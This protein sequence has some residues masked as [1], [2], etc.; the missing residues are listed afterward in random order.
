MPKIWGKE[1]YGKGANVTMKLSR[2]DKRWHHITNRL[3]STAVILMDQSDP[4]ADD[5]QRENDKQGI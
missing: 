2:N 4:M 1:L 3:R 5:H